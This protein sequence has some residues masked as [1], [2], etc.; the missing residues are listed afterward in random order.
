MEEA[1]AVLRD[2]LAGLISQIDSSAKPRPNKLN[3]PDHRLGGPEWHPD[4]GW[5]IRCIDNEPGLPTSIYVTSP[6]AFHETDFFAVSTSGGRI[7]A[8]AILAACDWADGLASGVT[9]LDARRKE[10]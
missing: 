2:Q 7:L 9:Q 8:M 4:K 10:A 5:V 1:V 3:P 6:D